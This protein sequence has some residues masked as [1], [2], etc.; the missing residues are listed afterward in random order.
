MRWTGRGGGL[1]RGRLRGSSTSPSPTDEVAAVEVWREVVVWAARAAMVP[2]PRADTPATTLVAWRL[3][4]SHLSRRRGELMTPFMPPESGSRLYGTLG[5]GHSLAHWI[6]RRG[7][8]EGAI[9]LAIVRSGVGLTPP[10]RHRL[11]G[12]PAHGTAHYLFR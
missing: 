6:F 12:I 9:R 3:R 7:F 8:P 10:P 5:P 4:R 11:A 2:T 1:G